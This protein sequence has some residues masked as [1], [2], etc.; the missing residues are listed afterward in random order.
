MVDVA[1]ALWGGILGA[2]A[3]AVVYVGFLALRL[4]QFD[5]LRFEG[6]LI[7]RER[8]NMVYIYGIVVKLVLGA[9]I[10]LGYRYVFEQIHS[11][12]YVG[13]GALIGL[14][15]GVLLLLVLP[16]LALINQNVR[17]G[18]D[19]DPGFAGLRGGRLTPV[20]LLATS[21]VFGLWVGLVLVP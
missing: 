9:A 21:V 11:A 15:Q 18:D 13:W 7:A 8:S 1:A 4:T 12:S 6:G 10:A 3:A 14:A 16:L 17:K 19:P 20:A 2:I 5:L